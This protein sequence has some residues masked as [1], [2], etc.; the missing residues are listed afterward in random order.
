MG[1][2]KTATVKAIFLCSCQKVFRFAAMRFE[3][4]VFAQFNFPAGIAVVS[5]SWAEAGDGVE[6]AG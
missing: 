4:F 2:T 5:R 1:H 3:I 6:L